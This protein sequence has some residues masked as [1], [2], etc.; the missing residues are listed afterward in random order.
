MSTSIVIAS[1]AADRLEDWQAFHSELTGPRRIEWAE[2]QRRR[3][4]TREAVFYWSGSSGPTAVYLVEGVEAGAAMDLL[5]ESAEPFDIWLRDQL[6][7][8]HEDLDFPVRK[9]DTRPPP[10]A[11]RGWRGLPFRSRHQ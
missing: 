1:I 3:G 11:W 9:S 10:G 5:G 8:L 6:A 4:I 2:S 7:S